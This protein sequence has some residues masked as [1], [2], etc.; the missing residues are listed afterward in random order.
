MLSSCHVPPNTSG[1][2]DPYVEMGLTLGELYSLVHA[3]VF[4]HIH[5]CCGM[6]NTT[7]EIGSRLKNSSSLFLLEAF[8]EYY[9]DTL[10]YRALSGHSGGAAMW[11]GCRWLCLNHTFYRRTLH[12]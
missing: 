9:C 10:N 5:Q 2:G 6:I 4:N 7:K 8:G 11:R 1:V 3:Q 12:S